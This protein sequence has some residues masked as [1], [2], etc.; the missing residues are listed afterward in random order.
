LTIA[1][2][3]VH[4]EVLGLVAAGGFLAAEVALGRALYVGPSLATAVFAWLLAFLLGLSS[5]ALWRLRRWGRG[6]VITWQLLQGAVAVAQFAVLPVVGGIAV[7]LA[8]VALVGLLAPASI[9]ATAGE[10]STPV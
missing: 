9:Q 3:V 8:L 2:L 5:R 7:A 4:L 10:T 6:P 1:L